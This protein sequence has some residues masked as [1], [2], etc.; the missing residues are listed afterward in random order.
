[1]HFQHRIGRGPIG[2]RIVPHHAER[3]PRQRQLLQLF[4]G[5][6]SFD[7][8]IASGIAGRRI[9][10]EL[11]FRAADMDAV[12]ALVDPGK[13][14]EP[15]RERRPDRNSDQQDQRD[16]RG[17]DGPLGDGIFQTFGMIDRHAWNS[18][19]AGCRLSER[20]RRAHEAAPMVETCR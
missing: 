10:D 5:G 18:F 12:G 7:Q 11:G 1:M 17:D 20:E 16:H 14:I 4:D 2:L 19:K 9:A 8:H 3:A 13:G 15:D 6:Q